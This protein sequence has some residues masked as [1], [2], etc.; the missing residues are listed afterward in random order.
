MDTNKDKKT[1]NFIDDQE[2]YNESEN[3][4]NISEILNNSLKN[5]SDKGF[6]LG[7]S[8]QI[9][10]KIEAKQQRKFNLKMYSLFSLLVVIGLGFLAVLFSEDQFL[11]MISLFLKY[12]F[13]ILFSLITVILIQISS[14]LLT[15]K[16][17]EN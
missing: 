13:I 15:S 3:D 17:L 2:N 7:F 12:K 8:N 14:R 10:R 16:E 5:S 4:F 1:Q 6:S 9:I 11:M